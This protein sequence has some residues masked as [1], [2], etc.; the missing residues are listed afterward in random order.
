VSEVL[1]LL[2]VRAAGDEASRRRQR[3]HTRC[4]SP[5][6]AAEH[7]RSLSRISG[8]SSDSVPHVVTIELEL[9]PVVAGLDEPESRNTSAPTSGRDLAL[10]GDDARAT[11]RDFWAS[12]PAVRG[13][14]LHVI[15]RAELARRRDRTSVTLLGR[16]RYGATCGR[17]ARAEMETFLPAGSRSPRTNTGTTLEQNRRL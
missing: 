10:N 16:R 13:R 14:L 4:R 9:R 1:A 5:S 2:G 3:A 11:T 17:E 6:S 8:Y 15:G 12:S 7:R